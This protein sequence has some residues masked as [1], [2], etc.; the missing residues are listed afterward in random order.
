[1][2]RANREARTSVRVVALCLAVVSVLFGGSAASGTDVRLD[3]A[4]IERLTGAKGTFN[5]QEGVFK[6]SVA[7][8]DLKV[9]AAGVKITPPL[10]SLIHI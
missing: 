5:E 9:S 1:M 2:M 10:L 7:R 3:T 6:V 8:T 4:Q